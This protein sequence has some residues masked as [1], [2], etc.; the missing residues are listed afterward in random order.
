MT[1]KNKKLLITAAVFAALS[2]I[3]CGISA[4]RAKKKNVALFDQTQN[5]DGN[6]IY[7]YEFPEENIKKISLELSYA[8][9]NLIGGSEKCKIE[10]INFSEDRFKMTVSATTIALEEKSGF[11]GIFSLN[12]KGLR[13]YL[14]SFRM[15]TKAKTVNIYLTNES[16]IKLMEADIYSGNVKIQDCI[17][18]CNYDFD[19]KYG[20][21]SA[22]GVTTE[23]KLSVKLYD[24]N[25]DISGSKIAT[26][27]AK[28]ER[29]YEAILNSQFTDLTSDI[30]TGYFKYQTGQYS[31]MSS[32]LKLVSDTG[33][34]RFGGDIYESGSFSQGMKYTGISS[35]VQ[36]SVDVHVKNGNIMI[37]E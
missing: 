31:L 19:I 21:L 23:E 10:L 27:D 4:I 29:G 36:T 30:V 25:L 17:N 35:V 18:Q 13:N 26:H 8:D 6:F 11:T 3:F 22:L 14:N 9:V 28:I 5:E 32:V 16:V 15:I 37:T 12:F 1:K 34:V 20:A 7:S 24:G 33:R 2:I